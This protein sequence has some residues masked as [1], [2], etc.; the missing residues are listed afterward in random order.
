MSVI[1]VKTYDFSG[2]ALDLYALFRHEPSLFFLDSSR[3]DP[4]RGRYSFIGFDPFEVFQAKGKDTLR[5][6]KER[7]G[8][9]R[10]EKQEIITPFASGI[11]GYLGY[12]YGLHQ[13]RIPL[14]PK[15][16]FGEPCFWRGS[17]GATRLRR[18]GLELPDAVFGFYDC[19]LTIDH[20]QKKLYVTSSGLPEKSGARREKRAIA[21]LEYIERKLAQP[22]EKGATPFFT[23]Y[24]ISGKRALSPDSDSDVSSNFTKKEYCAAVRKVLD[25]ISDGNIYQ[26]NL[27]QRFVC[28]AASD[29]LDPL[30]IYR[31]L[32]NLSPVSFGGY[33]DAGDVR[34]ISNSPE[35][36]LRLRNGYVQTRP[37][38]GTRPRGKE[39][40]EDQ[41]LRS[42]I[43]HSP[44][45]QA[46]LL[47]ITDLERNDL[48]KVCRYGSVRVEEMRAIEEYNY[49]FQATS[50]VAGV[51]REDKDCF[52]LIEACF[53]G[54]SITGCPKIRAMEIIEELE[55]TRRGPY[56][57]SMGYIDFSGNMD[58][59]ILIRTL[60]QFQQ[61]IYFQ[62]GGGIVADSTP[63]GEYAETLV[64]AR[65]MCAC[66]EPHLNTR[67]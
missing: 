64:K 5:L 52:D 48:G 28:D 54:G 11:V 15:A 39:N 14:R 23:P 19:V 20:F 10:Q 30:E 40:F 27:S 55:P 65:A 16:A 42:E 29:S 51:L 63:E 25:H 41:R 34:I 33:L 45:D 53:P 61:K 32:R 37:M 31:S 21:R 26:L 44:K 9:Y 4:Q 22:F 66:L 24:L 1:L 3:C 7:Y 49:V 46:E 6:L 2:D 13:E 12:D 58:L 62:V 36:F 8:Q 56:T 18:D 59:N 38:K 47:M 35:M 60:L 43:E 57:G 67:C 50:S 17:P